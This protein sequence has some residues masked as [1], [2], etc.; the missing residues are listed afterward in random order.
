MSSGLRFEQITDAE[1]WHD[2]V[3]LFS[4]HDGSA[5]ELLGY[6]YLDIFSRLAVFFSLLAVFSL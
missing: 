4:V 5:S 3:Q 1:V 2:T 6:F